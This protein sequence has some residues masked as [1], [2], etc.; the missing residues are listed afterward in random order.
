MTKTTD[1]VADL[2]RARADRDRA[3]ARIESLVSQLRAEGTSWT[4]IGTALGVQRTAA[5]KRYGART[6]V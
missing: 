3:E 2:A 6:L 1:L 4:V 5:H